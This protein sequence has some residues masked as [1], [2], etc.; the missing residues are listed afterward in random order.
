MLKGNPISGQI[1]V[2]IINKSL[3]SRLVLDTLAERDA[4]P[5]GYR[6]KGMI[7]YIKATREYYKF[8]YAGTENNVANGVNTNWQLIS[9]HTHSNLPALSLLGVNSS[10]LP[11]WNGVPLS[12]GG[13][14]GNGTQG[15]QGATGAQ[16]PQGVPGSGSGGSGTQGPQGVQG[17]QGAQ[18]AAGT[19][20]TQGP[21]GAPGSGTGTGTQGPQG[22]QGPQG[23]VGVGTQGPSGSQG[24]TGSTGLQGPQGVPGSGGTGGSG[25]VTTSFVDAGGQT[26]YAIASAAVTISKAGNKVSINRNGAVLQSCLVYFTST[27]V[28]AAAK[29]QID[30]DSTATDLDYLTPFFPQFQ[31]INDVS[32][33]RAYKTTAL[34]NMN[35]NAHTIECTALSAST[36]CWVNL[37]F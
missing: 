1:Y 2:D 22:A 26:M 35:I 31:V 20:G 5:S 19:N 17:A 12:S 7:V 33:N 29:V 18:G 37:S 34:G 13:G 9:F 28:G 25:S 16:G 32:G 3:D 21:Q 11:T 30:F 27:E 23:S 15:P 24:S 10:G 8:D 4:L 36:A 6:Y 14:T